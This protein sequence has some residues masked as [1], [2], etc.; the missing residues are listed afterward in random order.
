MPPPPLH[1]LGYFAD[2][3]GYVAGF[4]FDFDSRQMRTMID[5]WSESNRRMRNCWDSVDGVHAYPGLDL[6][7]LASALSPDAYYPVAREWANVDDCPGN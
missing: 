7:A 3:F 5:Y 6:I 2:G 4:H 1:S